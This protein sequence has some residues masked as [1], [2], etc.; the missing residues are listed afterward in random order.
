[1][2]NIRSGRRSP[3]GGC[4]GSLAPAVEPLRALAASLL[5]SLPATLRPAVAALSEPSTV[6]RRLADAIDRAVEVEARE[7]RVPASPVWSVIGAGQYVVAALLV[8][9]A[10]WFAALFVLDKPAVGSIE[11][12]PLGPVPAPV[13]FLAAVLVAGYVLTQLLRLH[14]GWMARRWSRRVAGRIRDGVESRIRDSLFVPLDA[15]EAARARLAR[16]LAQAREA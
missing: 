11:V 4:N 13:V 12:S 5:P 8:F 2:L 1:V 15:I 6:E 10:V 9:A 14:A 16:A 7:L 3:E